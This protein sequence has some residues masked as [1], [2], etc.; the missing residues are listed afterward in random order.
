MNL[1]ICHPLYGFIPV[2]FKSIENLDLNKEKKEK[3][4]NN[5]KK[6]SSFEVASESLSS[7]MWYIMKIGEQLSMDRNAVISHLKLVHTV[8]PGALLSILLMVIAK[9]LDKNYND[10]I[11]KADT[12]YVYS[13]TDS[14]I[15]SMPTSSLKKAS[16]KYFAAFRSKEEAVFGIKMAN[17]IRN[18]IFS[19]DRK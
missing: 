1:F 5:Q 7:P 10:H 8:S 4:E 12:V 3:K 13:T 11:S 2:S 18:F 17:I 6:N 16:F 14:K 9:E 15:Y 19:N